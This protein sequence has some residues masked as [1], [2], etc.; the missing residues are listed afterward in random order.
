MSNGTPHYIAGDDNSSLDNNA[1]IITRLIK[2]QTYYRFFV[3]W[4]GS[5]RGHKSAKSSSGKRLN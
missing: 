2:G 4:Y 1:K 5:I 3:T